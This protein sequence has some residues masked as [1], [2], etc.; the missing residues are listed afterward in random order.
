[1]AEH[2]ELGREGEQLAEAWLL[3][4]GYQILEKNWRYGQCE[5]DLIALKNSIPHL[6]EV[7]TRRWTPKPI[8]PEENVTRQKIRSLLK[9]AQGYLNYRRMYRDFRIDILSITLK[10]K[11][12]PQFF[13]IEDVYL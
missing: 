10:D 1:M 6:I 13:L 7:K 9:A 12:E 4:K 3:K 8:F 2:L 5:V 11:S